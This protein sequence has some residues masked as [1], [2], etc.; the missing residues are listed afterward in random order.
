MKRNNLN[1]RDFIRGSAVLAGT[2]LWSPWSLTDARAQTVSAVA[3]G[4]RRT[5]TDQVKLGN[6]GIKLSR[7]GIGTGVNGGRDQAVSGKEAFIRVVRH[8]YDQGI[9]YIDAAQRYETFPW[10]GDAIK[11]IPRERLYIQ[12]KIPG[13]PPEDILAAID[14]HRK[15]FNTDYIDSIL[16][17]CMTR[18]GWTDQWKRAMD[19]FAEAKERKWIRCKGVSCHRLGALREATA[20]DFNEVHLVR[21]NPQ[22]WHMDD[23][24]RAPEDGNADISNVMAEIKSMHAKGRGVIGMKIFGDGDF[25]TS[26]ARERSMRFAM[27]FKEINAIVIGFERTSEIDDTIAMMNRVLAEV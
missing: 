1:R 21:V 4:A 9:T 2:A 8:A 3:S 6:T 22:G 18:E 19:G 13:P 12:S 16:V 27:S 26:E 20:S 5:A 23:V 11:G 25:R 17:H 24:T 10:M 7:L 15:N 14:N